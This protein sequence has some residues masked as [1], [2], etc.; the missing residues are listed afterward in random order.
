MT[1]ITLYGVG[2]T[3]SAR[4][5]WTLLELGVPFNYV[6]NGKLIGTEEQK[7]RQ[8]LGKL[9]ALIIDDV[10]LF[11]SAAIC[12]YLCDRFD[13]T[14]GLSSEPGSWARAQHEQWTSFTLTELEAFLWHNL[15]HTSL[16]PEA[17]RVAQVIEPN[18]REAHLAL[19]VLSEHLDQHAYLV[20]D[21]FSVT[22]II[23]G[24]TINWA[25]RL[26]LTDDYEPIKAYLDRLFAR[27][28]CTFNPE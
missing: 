10:A 25:R 17:K 6:D 15:K 2:Y 18:N 7:T 22:D 23:G 19:A 26:G 13:S 20:D 28:L 3:R 9:P 27:D 21:T 4:C 8:P 1:D 11:E 24:W 5:R 14:R 12:T 16:Y